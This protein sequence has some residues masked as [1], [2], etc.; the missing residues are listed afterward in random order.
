MLRCYLNER[1]SNDMEATQFIQ[2]HDVIDI[3]RI[4]LSLADEAFLQNVLVERARNAK[5]GDARKAQNM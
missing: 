2:A 1:K 5:V 3:C 4:L